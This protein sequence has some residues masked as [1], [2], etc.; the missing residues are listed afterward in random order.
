MEWGRVPLGSNGSKDKL[1]ERSLHTLWLLK[2][3]KDLLFCSYTHHPY[4]MCRT[5]IGSSTCRKLTPAA[6]VAAC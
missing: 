6:V 1:V 4:K 3:E 5:S 2:K